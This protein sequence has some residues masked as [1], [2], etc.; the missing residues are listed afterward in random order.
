[1][2]RPAPL[3]IRFHH[4]HHRY[5]HIPAV[6]GRPDQQVHIC[7]LQAYIRTVY[8]HRRHDITIIVIIPP[9]ILHLTP[10]RRLKV[11]QDRGILILSRPTLHFHVVIDTV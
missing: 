7:H 1:M 2:T 8:H 10:H 5:H 9:H 6:T 3:R 4:R 11:R